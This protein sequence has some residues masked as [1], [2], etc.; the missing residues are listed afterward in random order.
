MKI[1][2]QCYQCHENILPKEVKDKKKI[3]TRT[4]K[5]HSCS[6]CKGKGIR[7][8]PIYGKVQFASKEVTES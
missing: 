2:A 6:L 1:K 4:N 8:C 5:S 7:K 3:K